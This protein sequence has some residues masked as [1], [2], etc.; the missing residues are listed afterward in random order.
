M[1]APAGPDLIAAFRRLVISNDGDEW[2]LARPDLGVF[3]DIPEAGAAFIS[4]VQNGATLAQAAEA[5]AAVAGEPVD[6]E[7]FVAELSAA[8]LLDEAIVAGPATE[9]AASR[10]R[11]IRWIEGVRPGAARRLFGP[12]AWTAYVMAALVAVGILLIRSD[13]RPDEGDYWALGDPVRSLLLLIPVATVLTG[14]HE[15]W[16]WLAGRAHGV[17][18][19]FRIS[20]RGVFLVF[21]TDLSQILL[22]PRRRRYGPFLAGM[23]FDAAILCVALVARLLGR[24]AIVDVPG[25][26]DRLLALI[27][28]INIV[29]IVW[30]FAG[31]FLRTDAYA[32]LANALR[33]NDL[34][35]VTWLT[36]RRRLDRGVPLRLRLGEPEMAELNAASPRDRAVARWFGIIYAVGFVVMTLSYVVLMLPALFRV[37]HFIVAHLVSLSPDSAAFW[38]SVTVMM[39]LVATSAGPALLALRERR[40]RR[41]DA[42][43]RSAQRPDH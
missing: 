4:A 21:E 28:I 26:V 1:T 25:F 42:M 38:E 40:L 33:C 19:V 8:G 30:Q 18:A 5:A 36:V 6:G 16:H 35:R 39:C 43:S 7:D 41:A 9:V 32:V 11:Q 31:V 14:G 29:G 37:L 24:L 20:Y 12:V 27:V 13:L 22:I 17:P 3:V 10:G 34:Y 23:A 2:V 15:A